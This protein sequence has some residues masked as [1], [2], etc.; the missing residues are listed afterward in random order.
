MADFKTHSVLGTM[1]GSAFG[2][3]CG[4]AGALSPVRSILAAVLFS[5]ASVLPD[6]DSS[7]GTAKK[8]LFETLAVLAPALIVLH[9]NFETAEQGVLLLL[10]LF[11]LV[12]YPLEFLFERCTEHRGIFH[13]IPMA[14]VLSAGQKTKEPKEGCERKGGK[15]MG[16]KAAGDLFSVWFVCLSLGDRP[17]SGSRP[18]WAPSTELSP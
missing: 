3:L 8:F 11:F 12:R 4:V 9:L 14:L 18:S 1:A 2:F 10:L 17:L 16:A 13:S 5:V 15:T 7:T 6:L